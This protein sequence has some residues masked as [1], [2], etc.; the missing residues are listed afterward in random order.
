MA[1]Q[2]T[3][4]WRTTLQRRLT[5]TAAVVVLWSCAIEARLVYLQVFERADLA[6]RADDQQSSQLT[7]PAKRGDIL[8]RN[9]HAA[10]L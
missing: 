5:V 6:A 9:G 8:D 10:R 2:P 7:S 1:E 4:D 3:N